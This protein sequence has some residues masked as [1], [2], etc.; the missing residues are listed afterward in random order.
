VKYEYVGDGPFPLHV[1]GRG[2]VISERGQI[3][4]TDEPIN[5]VHFVPVDE[6]RAKKGEK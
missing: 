1:I 4:E 2:L 5:H 6:K 3:V